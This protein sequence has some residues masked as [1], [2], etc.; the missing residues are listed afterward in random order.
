MKDAENTFQFDGIFRKIIIV[1]LMLKVENSAFSMKVLLNFYLINSI[2]MI[3]YGKCSQF[4]PEF[5][6]FLKLTIQR[7]SMRT[8]WRISHQTNNANKFKCV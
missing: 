3:I 7:S 4:S 8:L 2:W 1:V 5:R 6:S